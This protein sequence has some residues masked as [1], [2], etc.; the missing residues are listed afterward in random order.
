MRDPAKQ[1]LARANL[2]AQ[3]RTK[4]IEIILPFLC[5]WAAGIAVLRRKKSPF[6]A[7]VITAV[8]ILAVFFPLA[9]FYK[10]PKTETLVYSSIFVILPGSLISFIALTAIGY[11][12]VL[13]LRWLRWIIFAGPVLIPALYLANSIMTQMKTE[14][15][16][17]ALQQQLRKNDVLAINE[18]NPNWCTSLLD[19]KNQVLCIRRVMQLL[20]KPDACDSIY[21]SELK[22]SCYA[23]YVGSEAHSKFCTAGIAAQEFNIARCYLLAKAFPKYDEKDK[24]RTPLMFFASWGHPYNIFNS[25]DEAIDSI[26]KSGVAVNA[27]DEDGNTALHLAYK[28]DVVRSLLRKADPSIKNN[29]GQTADEARRNPK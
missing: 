14:E 1:I 28:E 23:L 12:Y 29:R 19:V 21:T 9:F 6:S 25:V 18:R 26:L 27:Q 2:F 3:S 17:E 24:N 13:N 20:G 22:A 4:M 10:G 11:T 8:V 16:A 15:A 5:G 7:G